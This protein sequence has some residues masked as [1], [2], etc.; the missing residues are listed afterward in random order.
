MSFG[1]SVGDL[2]AVR[3]LMSEITISLTATTWAG[4]EY[5]ELI[6]E[7]GSLRAAL[8]QVEQ[9]ES[10]TIPSSNL[11]SIVLS[12]AKP[13]EEFLAHIKTHESAVSV[14]RQ[15]NAVEGA[16]KK[17]RM[18][19]R[20][21]ELQSY[22]HLRND[23]VNNLL[24]EHG[25]EKLAELDVVV[26]TVPTPQPEVLKK[27]RVVGF[28]RDPIESISRPVNT[29]ESW[30]CYHFERH[31]RK[32]AHCHN[33]YEVHRNREQLCNVGHRLAQEVAK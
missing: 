25:L 23:D 20:L 4:S 1:F 29:S 18:L 27:E 16:S 17:I 22:L 12:C 33:P 32:C 31:A 3:K 30:A 28:Y 5:Q 6:R 7:I 26:P 24:T 13:L 19:L 11:T 9:L 14:Q 21:E 8:H 2:V 15:P 10:G